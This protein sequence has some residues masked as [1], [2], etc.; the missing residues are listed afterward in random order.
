M[1]I[2]NK[3]KNL[4]SERGRINIVT[5]VIIVAI[6]A[7]IYLAIMFIP[8]YVEHYKFEAKLRSVANAAHR[9]SKRN[10]EVMHKE[11]D[12]ELEN[13]GMKLPYDAV[14]IQFDPYGQWVELST[15]YAK[16]VKLVP[17]GVE[18]TLHFESLI[19]ER[20]D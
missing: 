9:P 3:L 10:N 7:A 17:F 19:I 4:R 11:I 15:Q 6:A 13:L 14:K 16:V 2:K 12:R 18:V 5:I 8:A 20:F 1:F